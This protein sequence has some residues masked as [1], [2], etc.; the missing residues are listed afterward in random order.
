MSRGEG[1]GQ[2]QEDIEDARPSEPWSVALDHRP[3]LRAVRPQIERK[4]R[5]GG[6]LERE[7]LRR[8]EQIGRV[9]ARSP[10]FGHRLVRRAGDM[11]REDRQ[12][13]VREGRRHDAPL[14]LPVVAFAEQQPVPDDRREDADRRRRPA[15][16][17]ILSTRTR[18]ME[19]APLRRTN[20][21]EKRRPLTTSS[22]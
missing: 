15:I 14:L 3:E 19:S 21:F 20:G 7:T 8:R 5:A 13:P 22:S 1:I 18:W 6:D 16:V 12:E 17:S 9:R 4:H 2:R 10:D 11:A